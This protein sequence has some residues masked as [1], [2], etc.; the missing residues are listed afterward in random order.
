[1]RSQTFSQHPSGTNLIQILQDR[2]TQ[3][4]ETLAYRFLQ[5]GEGESDWLTF[6]QLGANVQSTAAYLRTVTN[7]GD[8]V[9]LLYPPG[10]DFIVAFLGCL[11][12]QVIA[13][14]AYCPSRN[15]HF[16]RIVAIAQDAQ[17]SLLLTTHNWVERVAS[18]LQE[19][20][21]ESLW[22]AS[23]EG[24]RS[25]ETVDW[26]SPEIEPDGLAFL[27]YTSGSTGNPKGVMVSHNNIMAN[28][29]MMKTAM[30]YDESTRFVSWLPLF[31]DLGLISQVLQSL[32]LGVPCTLMPP[33]VF[34][35]KPH[36][37]LQAI[38]HYRATM[39][40]APNFAYDLCVSRI[41]AAQKATLDLSGW[42]VALNAAEPIR[43]ETLQRFSETFSECG[44]RAE[45]F[46]PAY[47]MAEATL[48][49][50][51]GTPR[52]SPILHSVDAAALEQHRVVPPL[53]RRQTLVGCGRALVGQQ[54]AVV[55]PETKVECP[56]GQIGELWVRGANITQGYWRR[57]LATR[58]TFAAYL[59]ETNEGPYLRTGDLGWL[60]AS[61]EF[62]FTGRQKDLII[63]RG[64]NYYPQDIERIA[65][66]SHPALRANHGA[67]F[68]IDIQGQ[69]QLVIAQEIVR[70]HRHHFKGVAIAQMMREAILDEFNLEVFSVVLLRPNSLLKT[71][72]GK[73]Q[74]RAMRQAYLQGTLNVLA[75][76]SLRLLDTEIAA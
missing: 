10:L 65:E 20:G 41:T 56:P 32:H 39:S 27:Q 67:A 42:E 19:A 58:E 71:S 43:A 4:P 59:A 76:L 26:L 75:E 29:E 57:D 51:G 68:S 33:S 8:R 66:K 50:T 28:L 55:D 38:S 25:T 46:Y 5:D 17:P 1:M 70:S 15:R 54:L 49:I 45:A 61:G 3:A 63:V 12:A 16:Q 60:D 30:H 34:V 11:C 23:L 31:H 18:Q 69:E 74:R 14:P 7:P 72:S 22:C 44:F 48:M 73:I 40:A 35:Q 64:R 9:L 52:Q 36:C 47:G 53:A 2:A 21:L 13:V 62:V 6:G 24:Q 37:W